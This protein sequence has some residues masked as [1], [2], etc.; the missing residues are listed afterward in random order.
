MKQWL[1]K[2]A[3]LL[4]TAC[5]GLWL[6]G[7]LG[8]HCFGFAANKLAYSNGTLQTKRLTAE[9]FDWVNIVEK[10]GTLISTNAD[11]QLILRD[12]G[13]RVDTVI[14]TIEYTKPPLVVTAFW[15]GEGQDY[16]VRRMAYPAKTTEDKTYFLLPVRGVQNLRIDPGTVAGNQMVVHSITVNQPRAFW[17][18]FIFSTTEWVLLLTAPGLLASGGWL[19]ILWIRRKDSKSKE[20]AKN[21]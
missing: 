17:E 9:D 7:L 18:F 20:G 16:S 19:I 3:A 5:Y 21:G 1:K 15:A 12:T 13:M 10:D 11:P 6:L 14:L 2:P 8:L 4:I